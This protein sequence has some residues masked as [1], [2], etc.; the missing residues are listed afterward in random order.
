VKFARYLV[1]KRIGPVDFFRRPAEERQNF[2]RLSG[3]DFRL[4]D[5]YGSAH[6]GLDGSAAALPTP[7]TSN[8]QTRAAIPGVPRPGSKPFGG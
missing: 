7:S 4:R 5:D 2:V 3:I 6:V 1:Q 8:T